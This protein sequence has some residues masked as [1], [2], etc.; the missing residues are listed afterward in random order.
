MNEYTIVLTSCGRFDLLKETLNSLFNSLDIPPARTIVI[1]DSGNPDVEHVV[2]GLK[3]PVEIVLNNPQIGQMKAIDKAYALVNTPYIFH[4]EDDWKFLRGGFIKESITIL[5]SCPDASMVCLRPRYELNPLIR[6]VPQLEISGIRCFA[7]DPTRHP[8]YFSHSF[9]PG[10]RRL[11]D[12][13]QLGPYAPKG[14]EEDISYHFK[15]A[16]FKIYNLENHAVIHIGNDRH[17]D[18]PTQPKRARTFLPKLKRSIMKRIKR[19]K[20][21]ING[22]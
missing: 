17:V 18:D 11:R 3:Y 9:N 12:Y 6:N 4:C 14:R 16:G 2:S 21:A 15:K 20:R 19:I 10:L 13:Q 5:E 7:Q 1:E 22:S 8:E